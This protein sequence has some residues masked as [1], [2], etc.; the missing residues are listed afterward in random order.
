[1]YTNT[2]TY[3]RTYVRISYSH[4]CYQTCKTQSQRR[5][6]SAWFLKI[7]LTQL[8]YALCIYVPTNYNLPTNADKNLLKRK[9]VHTHFT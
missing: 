7:C 8:I 4:V 3:V 6:K 5:T 2:Y 9:Y 1:M